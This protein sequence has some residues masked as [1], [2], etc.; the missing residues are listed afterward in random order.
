MGNPATKQ[1][2]EL[3][4]EQ[5]AYTNAP[6]LAAQVGS[7]FALSLMV[8]LARSYSRVFIVKSFGADDWTIVLALVRDSRRSR[9]RY[10]LTWCL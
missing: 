4:P 7:L 5:L 2:S 1:L 9:L 8:V 10:R 6:I 3:T